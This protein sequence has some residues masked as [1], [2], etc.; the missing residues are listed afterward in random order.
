MTVIFNETTLCPEKVPRL[1]FYNDFNKCAPI[2]KILSRGDFEKILYVYITKISTSHSIHC[3]VILR[4]AVPN[5]NNQKTC[6]L[7]PKTFRLHYAEVT[8]CLKMWGSLKISRRNPCSP[9]FSVSYSI[10]HHKIL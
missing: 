5:F 3:S 8:A 1:M 9:F 10:N 4:T 2:F 7:T 6:K